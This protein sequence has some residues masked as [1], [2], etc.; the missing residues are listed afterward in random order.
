MSQR[1][2]LIA[3][4]H[5]DYHAEHVGQTADGKQF[6]LTTP[7]APSS[8]EG[9]GEYIAL[10]LFDNAGTL[11]EARIDELGQR[12]TM[13]RAERR[14]LYEARLLELGEVTYQRINVA[15]FVL[16]R[17]GTTFGLVVRQPVEKDDIWAVEMQPGNY[18]A[19]FEPWDSGIY[20]T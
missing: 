9:G 6:F 3:I 15:P 18:M 1:P 11:L 17:F 7:F 4:E 8:S 2:D 16:E 10:Y 13:D 19:F 20:D 14:R 12:A 5:D